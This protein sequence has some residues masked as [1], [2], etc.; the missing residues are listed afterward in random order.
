MWETT[1]GEDIWDLHGVK[2]WDNI[3]YE[4]EPHIINDERNC[5]ESDVKIEWLWRNFLTEKS[6][7]CRA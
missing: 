5:I 1:G 4:A 7:L 6:W 2:E 3:N